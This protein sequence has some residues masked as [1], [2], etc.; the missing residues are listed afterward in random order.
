MT[1]E[2][3]KQVVE[4]GLDRIWPL[5]AKVFRDI[6]SGT[7]LWHAFRDSI[8]HPAEGDEWASIVMTSAVCELLYDA[9]GSAGIRS[10]ALVT[11]EQLAAVGV[12]REHLEYWVARERIAA[13]GNGF[14]V[15]FV[16]PSLGRVPPPRVPRVRRSVARSKTARRRARRAARAPADPSRPDDPSRPED[17]DVTAAAR[18]GP[19][20][21]P[22]AWPRHRVG[23]YG[24][25]VSSRGRGRG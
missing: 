1:G 20:S 18:Q 6:S 5:R 15:E 21:S 12:S 9:D 10:P 19:S 8:L 13:V 7:A 23:R 2:L 24:A 25:G 16:I 11:D 3:Y 14:Q 4:A 22:R 17:S